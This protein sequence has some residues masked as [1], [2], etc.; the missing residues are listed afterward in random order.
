LATPA[1]LNGG[2][3]GTSR[4]TKGGHGHKIASRGEDGS[5]SDDSAPVGAKKMT[6]IQTL[7]ATT[8]RSGVGTR[9]RDGGAEIYPDDGIVAAAR[10]APGAKGHMPNDGSGAALESITGAEVVMRALAAL[11]LKKAQSGEASSL[12]R[13]NPMNAHAS[14]RGGGGDGVNTVDED[15]SYDDK[16]KEASFLFRLDRERAHASAKGVPSARVQ[17][18]DDDNL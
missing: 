17:A 14:T 10:S 11:P 9:C 13:L 8:I 12:F 5:D 16:A 15:D 7:V 1:E 18:V 6:L 4:K 3:D 2:V